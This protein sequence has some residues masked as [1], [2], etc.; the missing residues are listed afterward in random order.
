[1]DARA[2]PQE[3]AHGSPLAF[4]GLMRTGSHFHVRFVGDRGAELSWFGIAA[5]SPIGARDARRAARAIVAARAIIAAAR[6]GRPALTF[7][8]T[9]HLLVLA[10]ALAPSLTAH[11]LALGARLLPSADGGDAAADGDGPIAGWRVDSRWVPSWLTRLG[12]RAAVANL[13]LVAVPPAAAAR[14]GYADRGVDAG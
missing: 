5:T 14:I 2:L 13:D 4:P 12:D 6:Q 8:V 7:N 11:A 10:A 3:I 1:M 9:A